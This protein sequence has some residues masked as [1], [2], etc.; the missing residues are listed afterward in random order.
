MDNLKPTTQPGSSPELT[1]KAENPEEEALYCANHPNVETLLRCN[2]CGKPICTRCA[3]LTDVGYRCKE[4]IR[5][6]QNIYFNA[7]TWDNPI[8]FGVGFAVA[9]LGAPIV[10]MLIGRFGFLGL[11]VAFFIGSGAGSL[12]AQIIR[13]A[14]G[15]RRGRY[16]PL[17]ALLGII[18]GVLAGNLIFLLFL[19]VFPLFSLPMLLFA[20]LAIAAAYPQLR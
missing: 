5:S 18:L 20:G 15:R 10:G 19:G 3:V 11:I 4:C 9:A 8:A 13:K 6:H 7:T 17:F 14:V 2:R 12:L 1:P 16:L